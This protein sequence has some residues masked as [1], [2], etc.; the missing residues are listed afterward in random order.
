MNLRAAA[1]EPA[2]HFSAAEASVVWLSLASARVSGGSLSPAEL[3][4]FFLNAALLTGAVSAFA[5][6]HGKT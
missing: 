2:V 6:V 3:G 4:S 5:G 1:L